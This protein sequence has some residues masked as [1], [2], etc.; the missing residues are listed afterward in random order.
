LIDDSSDFGFHAAYLVYTKAWIENVYFRTD[1]SRGENH[2]DDY[3]RPGFFSIEILPEERKSF[4]LIAAGGEKEKE[5]IALHESISEIKD[6]ERARAD[7]IKRKCFLIE[8]FHKRNLFK[9][10]N[11]VHKPR[12]QNQNRI[13]DFKT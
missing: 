2:L 6:V 3:Y 12:R 9:N 10:E 4:F 13:C 5:V 1:E 11:W 8:E 7:E